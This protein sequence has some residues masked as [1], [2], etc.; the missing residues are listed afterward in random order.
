MLGHNREY[1]ICSLETHDETHKNSLGSDF[2]TQNGALG[3][4]LI[5]A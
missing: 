2:C 5:S 4:D 3:I 1:K